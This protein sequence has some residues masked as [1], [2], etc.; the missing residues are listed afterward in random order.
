MPFSEKRA[1]E[2]RANSLQSILVSQ[3]ELIR[4]KENERRLVGGRVGQ[5]EVQLRSRD[6]Q[7]KQ[8]T[9]R[10]LK[11]PFLTRNLGSRSAHV[12][13][14]PLQDRFEALNADWEKAQSDIRK[15]KE[16]LEASYEERRHHGTELA[17]LSSELHRTRMQLT[18]AAATAEVSQ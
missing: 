14:S 17:N 2:S 6:A 18:E 8:L 3:E 11:M 15:M 9:V 16:D 12:C 7:L 1:T 13:T 5:L 10:P 4:S